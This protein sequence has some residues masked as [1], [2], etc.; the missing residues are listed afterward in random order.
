MKESVLL[1]S[2]KDLERVV[3][4]LPADRAFLLLLENLLDA[5]LAAAQVSTRH[6]DHAL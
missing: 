3:H 4:G 1:S 2:C 6:D 5:R